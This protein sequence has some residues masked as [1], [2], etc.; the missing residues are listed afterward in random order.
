M[1]SFRDIHAKVASI[2]AASLGVDEDDVIPSATLQGD[3]GAESI[4]FLD[5]VF[6]LEREFGI[7]IPQGELFPDS[8][9]GG[10]ADLVQEGRVTDR[11][12]AELRS[13]MPYADLADFERD[14]RFS[15][16]ADLFTVRLVVR[17]VEWK[18]AWDGRTVTVDRADPLGGRDSPVV[19]QPL[20]PGR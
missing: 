3:L 9:L 4:D 10:Q 5:I 19:H 12:M 13:R 2:L 11:G 20:S 1:T 7:K 6:R 17:Y 15:A 8:I 18:L 14:R 16:V